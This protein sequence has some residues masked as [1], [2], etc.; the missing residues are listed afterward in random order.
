MAIRSARKQARFRG[1]FAILKMA[2]FHVRQLLKTPFFLQTALL[3]PLSF[4]LLKW[5]G[6]SG[7]QVAVTDSFWVEIS[8]AGLWASTTT[9][10]GIVGFQR[11]QGTLEHLATSVL[12][13][14]S[15]FTALTAAAAALGLL[16]VPIGIALQ[17]FATGSVHFSLSSVCSI[18]LAAVACVASAGVLAS[19]FVLT[20]RATAFEPLLLIPVW[21]LSGVVIPTQTLPGWIQA[22]AWLH[23]LSGA[24]RVEHATTIG[25]ALAAAGGSAMVSLAW[26]FLAGRLLSAATKRARAE[27]TLALS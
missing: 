19:L 17:L 7:A 18:L 1:H 6:Y 16:S 27:G 13:P 12:Q 21:L 23:P 26:I 3:A 14:R 22:V 10:V 20:R 25:E 2:S 5:L 15:V 4:G 24:V 9:A 11:F 8:I